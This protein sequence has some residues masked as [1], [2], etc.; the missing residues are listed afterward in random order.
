MRMKR[1]GRSRVSAIT[2]TPAS[3]PFGP[4][5]TPPMSSLSMATVLCACNWP[6]ASASQPVRPTTAT[7]RYNA[8]FIFID[9]SLR[10]IADRPT[11]LQQC[12]ARARELR[13]RLSLQPFRQPAQMAAAA[14]FRERIRADLQLEHLG[15]LALAAFAVED[16][17]RAGRGPQA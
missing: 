14:L 2:H 7:P 3:G 9:R 6:G 1:T 17:P 8:D 5:T 4:V 13:Y 15:L 10:I 16:R 11:R 12:E